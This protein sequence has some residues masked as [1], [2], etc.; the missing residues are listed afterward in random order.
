MGDFKSFVTSDIEKPERLY[1]RRR[2]RGPKTINAILKTFTI[3]DGTFIVKLIP[4]LN[5]SG[6][7]E[8]ESDAESMLKEILGDY[9]DSILELKHYKLIHDLSKYGWKLGP[10][11]KKTFKKTIPINK[12][13]VLNE[14]GLPK[15]TPIKESMLQVA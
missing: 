5:I 3:N 15:N 10:Y 14:F 7:G 9:F 2:K 12:D 4:A 6:Y 13:I 11:S 1:I 8:T